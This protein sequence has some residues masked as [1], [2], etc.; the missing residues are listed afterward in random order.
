M[1]TIETAGRPVSGAAPTGAQTVMGPATTV[2]IADPAPLGLAAF[3]L[4]T[5]VLSAINAGLINQA[6]EPL[7]LGLAIAYGGGAQ[8][9]AGMWAFRRGNTFAATAFSSY[10][11]FWLSFWLIVQFF[12]PMIIAGT[13]KALGPGATAAQVTAAATNNLN[14]ILGLYLFV[15][16]VFTAYMFIAS[17][18]GAKAVQL[19]FILLT[20]TFFALAAGKWANSL[21]WGHIGGYLGIA[22][23]IAAFY[24][25]FADVA[26]ANFKRT[27][28][29]TGAPSA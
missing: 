26:N 18:A 19:V 24:T 8:L 29:P 4:T 22:T 7:V 10:G 3:A 20:L 13:A 12:V 23:A 5:L 9:L 28:L 11:A 14:A 2:T 15:W 21:S 25:S 16:G 27:V 6:T 1:A 17:L